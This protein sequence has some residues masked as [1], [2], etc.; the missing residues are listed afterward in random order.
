MRIA[1]VLANLGVAALLCVGV[2]TLPERWWVVDVLGALTVASLVAGAAG[3]LLRSPRGL[4]LARAGAVVV[5]VAGALGVA[6]LC[7]AAAYVHGVHGVLG[8]GVAFAYLLLVACSATWLVIFPAL[9]LVW[10][11]RALREG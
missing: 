10:L 9:Q 3:L 5:L 6:A 4:R 8:R 1:L 11:H 7:L 2:V